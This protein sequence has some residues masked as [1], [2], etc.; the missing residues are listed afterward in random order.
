[1]V[2]ALV[3]V[4]PRAHGKPLEVTSA[5]Y[6]VVE[7]NLQGMQEAHALFSVTFDQDVYYLDDPVCG[8]QMNMTECRTRT[9]PSPIF[10]NETGYNITVL[11]KDQWYNFDWVHHDTKLYF[12]LQLKPSDSVTCPILKLDHNL[13]I[14]DAGMA[15][16]NRFIP[17]VTNFQ[18]IKYRW[19]RTLWICPQR[20][21]WAYGWWY[22][23]V[24]PD[25]P[26]V[27]YLSY[28]IRWS[29]KDVDTCVVIP[30]RLPSP[31]PTTPL[32]P[33]AVVQLEDNIPFISPLPP[34]EFVYFRFT[35]NAPC[36]DFGVSARALTSYYPGNIS[37][38]DLF[39]S[40][41]NPYPKTMEASRNDFASN[42][43]HEDYLT[44]KNVCNLDGAPT[45]TF[46]IGLWCWQ[47]PC[48]L[49]AIV[50]TSQSV[51]WSK[52]PLIQNGPLQLGYM[53]A[54]DYARM[55]CGPQI[56][57]WQENFRS[58][59]PSYPGGGVGDQ[60]GAQI[61]WYPYVSSNDT[62]LV[63]HMW[64]TVKA[65]TSFHYL[66]GLPWTKH[67]D[68][69]VNVPRTLSTAMSLYL[70]KQD[71]VEF[72]VVSPIETC[73]IHW[74][75]V[76]VNEASEPV[77]GVTSFAR[78][79]H[80]CN[81]AAFAPLLE[82]AKAMIQTMVTLTTY[83]EL[84]VIQMRLQFLEYSD[85]WQACRHN[86]LDEFFTMG[87]QTAAVPGPSRCLHY[88]DTDEWRADPCC[89][90]RAKLHSSCALGVQDIEY[91]IPVAVNQ[92]RIQSQCSVP[93][94]AQ[95][96]FESYLAAAAAIQD[97]V[98]GCSAA[99][100]AIAGPAMVDESTA[101]YK[102][103][104]HDILGDRL[105][106]LSCTFN[107][108]CAVPSAPYLNGTCN[109]RTFKCSYSDDDV[110]L[111]WARTIDPLI[112]R[113][114][115]DLWRISDDVSEERLLSEFNARFVNPT[116][117][118]PTGIRFRENHNFASEYTSCTDLCYNPAIGLNLQ[119]YCL[120]R[121]EE[122]CPVPTECSTWIVGYNWCWRQW[123][124]LSAQPESA[125]VADKQCNWLPCTSSSDPQCA[126][127]CLNSSA[128]SSVCVE[129]SRAQGCI[130]VFNTS[131]A[132]TTLLGSCSVPCS[133][134]VPCADQ[135]ACEATGVCT[136]DESIYAPESIFAHYNRSGL[137]FSPFI[138]DFLG[139]AYCGGAK[140]FDW[141]EGSL[142][143]PE[144]RYGCVCSGNP[145]S[146]PNCS[147]A[148]TQAECDQKGFLW[149]NDDQTQ[150]ACEVSPARCFTSWQAPTLSP[151]GL[152]NTKT[153]E[154]CEAAGEVFQSVNQWQRGVWTPA[155]PVTRVASPKLFTSINTWKS[156]IDYIAFGAEVARASIARV[157]LAYSTEALCRYRLELD[158]LSI[159]T[160]DCS[161]ASVGGNACYPSTDSRPFAVDRVC[162]YLEATFE[163][164]Q[165]TITVPALAFPP[166]EFCQNLYLA[167]YASVA[168]QAR[169]ENKISSEIFVERS[170][171]PYV[172]VKNDDK[173]V[174]GQILTDGINVTWDSRHVLHA[175]L[176]LCIPINTA[177]IEWDSEDYPTI[178]VGELEREAG[179]AN[180]APGIIHVGYGLRVNRS[181][182]FGVDTPGTY[183]GTAVVADVRNPTSLLDR[184]MFGASAAVYAIVDVLGI[185]QLVRYFA[186][187]RHKK[188]TI[189]F[190]NPI[191]G[192]N[193][194]VF[195]TLRVAY[196]LIMAVT[197]STD[198]NANG[199][200]VVIFEFASVLFIP[201]ITGIFYIWRTI[202]D[203]F[204]KLKPRDKSIPIPL[205]FWASFV[206][207]ISITLVFA[208]V[209]YTVPEQATLP[210][211]TDLA[212]TLHHNKILTNLG[213]V[214]VM[215]LLSVIP[216]LI[217]PYQG[218]IFLHKT[219]RRPI[220]MRATL[221]VLVT[222]VPM[223][224]IK[225]MLTLWSA[226]TGG[227]VPVLVYC[228]LEVIPTL[229]LEYYIYPIAMCGESGN[230]SNSRKKST[231]KAS[232]KS[233]N[234]RGSSTTPTTLSGMQSVPPRSS[235]EMDAASSASVS[236]SSSSAAPHKQD[237][238][239]GSVSITA[240]NESDVHISPEE[241]SESDYH[242][243]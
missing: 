183:F 237:D 113:S 64:P 134:G 18:F 212:I 189:K 204:D 26:R 115:F 181:I 30:P 7:T 101:F 95:Q 131:C 221:S 180:T 186:D 3:V 166:E 92:Q 235:I 88:T 25:I 164:A 201:M 215:A 182:C 106:G 43:E 2:L 195:C 58:V 120:E 227:V 78:K 148:T 23:T 132:N 56:N 9:V 22:L 144:A 130:G 66:H 4:V 37:D 54:N 216:V 243:L 174:V 53:L 219:G 217:Y 176:T 190:F 170:A 52:A 163:H 232:S 21:E 118:G 104:R 197:G 177:E 5:T 127:A 188:A 121:D 86:M 187:D 80:K 19:S 28:R 236:A 102:Q 200:T 17:S 103:C 98:M 145:W 74:Q 151:P 218:I 16:S 29:T 194:I 171:N 202:V 214:I 96:S 100:N 72:Y 233:P 203:G 231:T 230:P 14:G 15:I 65:D 11:E 206:I 84:Q 224:A 162:P 40:L 24:L 167:Q 234:S 193:I 223:F 32:A 129:C 240:A 238:S 149:V 62:R 155:Q 208:I 165:V 105:E 6:E 49:M 242:K 150:R 93:Q 97:P 107:S 48:D 108:D 205:P 90:N 34:G 36:S 114:L 175:K 12:K 117:V 225:S 226:L 20:I 128:P 229:V 141:S 135:A 60:W 57:G 185:I 136:G 140:P 77:T 110:L 172:I 33:G 142:V 124:H 89:N 220:V 228:A 51:D 81:P 222:F 143:L 123:F 179:G 42:T 147:L 158:A 160:C 138:T 139:N 133:G 198:A 213:Y 137:C 59:Y 76:L 192:A 146:H 91:T 156:S 116:C 173:K 50:A 210:C 99:F 47:G 13:N 207:V 45:T 112:A 209:F 67:P 44:M 87:N 41:T 82:E 196:M 73:A 154:Q 83:E 69:T 159:Y 70:R 239:S 191:L 8:C 79:Q 199:A 94:C 109:L 211:R 111:C 61:P 55:R 71:W 157:A 85:A 68:Y 184:A 169:V 35:V 10:V 178:A 152:Y 27:E 161:D 31:V 1:M 75:G 46:H 63:N 39:V 153:R 119:P 38:I 168:F 126:S 125:C 122:Y 241:L